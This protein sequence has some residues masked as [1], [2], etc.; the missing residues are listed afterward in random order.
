MNY[1]FY[2][3]LDEEVFSWLA[4][5]EIPTVSR[6]MPPVDRKVGT[7]IEE[8]L[9][10]RGVSIKDFGVR[11]VRKVYFKSFLRAA[12][13]LPRNFRWGPFLEDDLYPDRR[14]VLLR[15]TLPPGSFAT[16]LVKALRCG[17]PRAGS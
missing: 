14:K 13:V 4:A 6:K 12:V 9:E 8:V 1:R 17:G 3:K 2:G 11:D 5:L 15:F 10:E 7:A 16:M